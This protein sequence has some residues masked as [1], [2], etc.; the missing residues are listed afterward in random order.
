[1]GGVSFFVGC[2]SAATSGKRVARSLNPGRTRLLAQYGQVVLFLTRLP[3]IACHSC[4]HSV[5]IHQAFLSELG[6]TSRAVQGFLG[7]HSSARSG[8][9]SATDVTS[10]PPFVGS[11]P[12][13][14]TR[15]SPPAETGG[16]FLVNYVTL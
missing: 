11:H 4:P 3:T 6:F 5:P 9:T 2:H 15:K 16:L 14:S 7:L 1:S 8:L 10:P 13:C 12:Q